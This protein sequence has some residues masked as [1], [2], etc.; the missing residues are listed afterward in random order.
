MPGKIQGKVVAITAAGGLVTDISAEQLRGAPTDESV[1]VSCD[2]H[3]T[4]GIFPTDH[5]QPEA[6]FL[7]YLGPS[8]ALELDIVGVGAA[9]MLGVRVGEKV[10]VKW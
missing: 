2:E 8:G 4:C 3:E 1:L 10:V 5:G 7:A 6:T 9:P